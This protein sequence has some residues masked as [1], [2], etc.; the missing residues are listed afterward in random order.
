MPEAHSPGNWRVEIWDYTHATPPRRELNI[1]NEQFLIATV[2]WDEKGDNP[3]TIP[4]E[5]ALAN[6]RLFASSPRLL[7]VL[8]KFL[9]FGKAGGDTSWHSTEAQS[10]FYE[11]M[12]ACG[13]ADGTRPI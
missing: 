4:K 1:Q 12:C 13:Q 9:Q 8:Q 10:L 2:Q 7:A 6:A 11:M 3:Y 5:Q